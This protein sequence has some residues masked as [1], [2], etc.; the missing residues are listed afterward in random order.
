MGGRRISPLRWGWR[1]PAIP[2][3]AKGGGASGADFSPA[4]SDFKMLGAFFCHFPS[5]N[6]QAPSQAVEI[7]GARNI[8]FRGFLRFQWLTPLEGQ[9]SGRSYRRGRGPRS[10]RPCRSRETRRFAPDAVGVGRLR[11]RLRPDA[12]RP[13]TTSCGFE[14]SEAIPFPGADSIFSSCC[15]AIARQRR[16]LARNLLTV[17]IASCV[18]W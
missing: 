14:T 6:R 7:V 16:C 5:R 3:A 9:N 18:W 15:G 12:P 4:S 13:C 8:R 1:P 11:C 10:S 17:G 2:A